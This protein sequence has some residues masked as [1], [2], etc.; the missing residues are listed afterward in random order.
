MIYTLPLLEML[1]STTSQNP[2]PPSSLF[3]GMGDPVK[4]AKEALKAANKIKYG[5]PAP[6][7]Q[8][9]R[10]KTFQGDKR[11]YRTGTPNGFARF[12]RKTLYAIRDAAAQEAKDIVKH[13]IDKEMG[14][15]L[16]N[17]LGVE[18]LEYAVSVVRSK[19]DGTNTRLSAAKLILEYTKQK[20]ATKADLTVRKAEDF[21]TDIANDMTK[22]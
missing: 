6:P 1:V 16:D 3:E 5:R 12:K 15:P 10:F 4:R 14:A 11:G 9:A 20:P 8:I 18:A 7:E 17:A 2:P 19:V 21:L 13:M 22:G